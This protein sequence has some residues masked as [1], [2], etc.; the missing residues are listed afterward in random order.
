MIRSI[1]Q[2]DGSALFG[3]AAQIAFLQR[4]IADQDPYMLKNICEPHY[5]FDTVSWTAPILEVA[6]AMRDNIGDVSETLDKLI[7]TCDKIRKDH[8]WKEWEREQKARGAP[9]NY[10]RVPVSSLIANAD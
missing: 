8:L 9:T 6:N 7:E 2:K 10:V 4:L 1:I 5:G 3:F